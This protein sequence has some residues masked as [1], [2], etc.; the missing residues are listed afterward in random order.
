MYHHLVACLIHAKMQIT[1][2]FYSHFV[3]WIS[4]AQ[5]S[6]LYVNIWE[7]IQCTQS[8]LICFTCMCGLT[9]FYLQKALILIQN[10]LIEMFI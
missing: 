8:V 6:L 4:L 5:G 9:M 10:I 1:L 3:S 2:L 7:I